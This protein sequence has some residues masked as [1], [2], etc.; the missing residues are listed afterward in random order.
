MSD[1]APRCFLGLRQIV[2]EMEY[3]R[4]DILAQAD[5][6]GRERP[7]ESMGGVSRKPNVI[8]STDRRYWGLPR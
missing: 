1:K 4:L 5:V 3:P 7:V 8:W 6:E 2:L